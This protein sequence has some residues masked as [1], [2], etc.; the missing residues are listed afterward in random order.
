M[1]D[2]L[3]FW[4]SHG[5]QGFRIDAIPY[6]FEVKPDARGN[7][8]DEPLTGPRPG[9]EDCTIPDNYCYTQHIYTQDQ[10]ETF[11]MIYQWRE[12]VDNYARTHDN[13]TK[14]IMTEAYTAL[15]NIIKFYGD[16]KR[17]G[18]HV[19]FNFELISNVDATST[20]KDYA[21]RIKI[22]YDKVPSGLQPNWV[23][24]NHDN[25][26]LGSRLGPERRDLINILLQTLPGIAVTYQGEELGLLNTDLTWEETID[27][28]A[29]NTNPEE[30]ERYSRDGCRTPFPWDATK[31][32]GFSTADKTWLP[33][34]PDY[35]T[36]NVDYQRNE[37][38]SHLKIFKQLT[39]LRK[40][41]VLREGQYDTKLVNN[42]NVMIYR[43]WYGEE[44]LV[45]VILNFGSQTETVN[46]KEH[47]TM[48]TESELPLYTASQE[49]LTASEVLG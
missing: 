16:G 26:R 45:V 15:D 10:P 39:K 46:V 5:I 6:L 49:I 17:L 12:L 40:H 8:P 11:D 18:S 14:V 4:L 38:H 30:Y 7:Y 19:P 41:K 42:D 29:C 37:N 13:V 36:M 2:V 32:A 31:N 9:P 33:V 27:P 23:L 25:H 3:T 1:K 48:I 24:G 35:I 20:A 28:A 43:R 34:K 47:F 44:D 21:E 22:F